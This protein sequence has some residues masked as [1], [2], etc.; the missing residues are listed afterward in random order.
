M[1]A[2]GVWCC[3]YVIYYNIYKV[4]IGLCMSNSCSVIS[5]EILMDMCSMF[6]QWCYILVE[7]IEWMVAVGDNCCV[8]RGLWCRRSHGRYDVA[9]TIYTTLYGK[10]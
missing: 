1:A 5:I 6:E 7:Y 3:D 4:V 10:K 9:V 8:D 2:V